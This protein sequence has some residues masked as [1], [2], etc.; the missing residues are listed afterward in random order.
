MPP[1]HPTQQ[2]CTDASRAPDPADCKKEIVCTR[3]LEPLEIFSENVTLDSAIVK[4]VHLVQRITRVFEVRIM[5]TKYT[6]GGNFISHI[7]LT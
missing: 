2:I 7:V 1:V 4:S 3:A 5:Y 6:K